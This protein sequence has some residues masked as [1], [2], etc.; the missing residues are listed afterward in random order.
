MATPASPRAAMDELEF[1]VLQAIERALSA[2]RTA[3]NFNAVN[4]LVMRRQAARVARHLREAR[5]PIVE[6]LMDATRRALLGGSQDARADAPEPDGTDIDP[7]MGSQVLNSLTAD[8]RNAVN[9][10]VLQAL[11]TGGNRDNPVSRVGRAA[12]R[13]RQVT[14]TKV[15][16][17]YNAGRRWYAN[18]FKFDLKWVTIGDSRTCPICE[19]LDGKILGQAKAFTAS[20]AEWQGVAGM[21]PAHPN[22]RCYTEV[23]RSSG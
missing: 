17:A 18:L 6:A 4:P 11:T 7:V 3:A 16:D 8:R 21:P 9:E 1:E 10:E 23:V 13:L 19:P 2:A 5:A 14:I 22:C 15:S 12:R 20:R